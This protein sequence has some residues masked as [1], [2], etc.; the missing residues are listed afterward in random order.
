MELHPTGFAIRVLQSEVWD[1]CRLRWERMPLV[2]PALNDVTLPLA[3]L[4]P[5]QRVA[6]TSPRVVVNY[7]ACLV[8]VGSLRPSYFPAA[9]QVTPPLQPEPICRPYAYER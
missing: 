5:L 6:Y 7:N 9:I 8:S 3:A 1:G 2:R 4:A